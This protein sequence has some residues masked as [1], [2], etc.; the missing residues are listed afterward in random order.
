MRYALTETEWSIIQSILPNK[1]RG[2]SRVDDRR[3]ERHLLGPALGC[4]VTRSARLRWP[5][6]DLLQPLQPLAEGRHLGRYSEG[7]GG[8][9]E[10][11]VQMLDIVNVY[12][13]P[14]GRKHFLSVGKGRSGFLLLL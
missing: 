11:M 14:R 2:I 1:P 13:R 9:C 12:G 5:V 10:A 6:H 8:W 7:R 4:T 3:I